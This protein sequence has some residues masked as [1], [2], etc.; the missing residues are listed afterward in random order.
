MPE[1]RLRKTSRYSDGLIKFKAPYG[2]EEYEIELKVTPENKLE[3]TYSGGGN[4]GKT[5]GIKDQAQ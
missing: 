2:G 1:N 5:T 4:S 3:G